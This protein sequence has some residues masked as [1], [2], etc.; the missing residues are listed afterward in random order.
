MMNEKSTKVL[1]ET[2]GGWKAASA[3]LMADFKG[4]KNK[5]LVTKQCLENF[6]KTMITEGYNGVTSASDISFIGSVILPLNRRVMPTLMA[7]ELVGVQALKTPLGQIGTLRTKY[8]STV[9]ADKSGVI[10]GE[11]ALGPYLGDTPYYS[12]NGNVAQPGAAVTAALESQVGPKMSVEIVMEK[13][14]AKTRKLSAQWTPEAMQDAQSTWSV[15]LQNEIT[16]T[17]AQQIGLDK[18][19]E[20]LFALRALAGVAVDTY[21]QNAVSGV[22]TSVVDEHAALAV[23]IQRYAN[24]IAKKLRQGA[25]NWAV[26]TTDQ[27]TMLQSAGASRFVATTQG[28][29]EAPTNNKQVGTLNGYMKVYADTYADD[30]EDILIGFKGQGEANAAL[31]YCPYVEVLSTPTITDPNTF[32]QVIGMMTR[33]GIAMLTNS[34]NSFG[35]A[36]DY[37]SRIAVRNARYI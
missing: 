28:E 8:A 37:L 18:D 33:Y 3:K 30:S 2:A 35:N 27:E 10:A 5:E 26:V 9:P 15:N 31:I 23:M 32:N 13:V 12:G 25:A 6:R 36:G 19:R 21:D 29:F 17:L 4:S 14:E 22:A 11:E 7:H 20:L 1:L 34:N 16:A 24:K